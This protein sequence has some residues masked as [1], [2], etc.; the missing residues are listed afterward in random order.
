MPFLDTAFVFLLLIPVRIMGIRRQHACLK[1][2]NDCLVDQEIKPTLNFDRRNGVLQG[3][4]RCLAFNFILPLVFCT[5]LLS[6][7][8]V[9]KADGAE[10][11]DEKE[12]TIGVLAIRGKNVCRQSWQNTADYLTSRIPG[13]RFT[14]TPLDHTEINHSVADGAVDFILT[15]SSTYVELE[16]LYGINRIA[17]LKEKRHGGVYSSYGGVIFY[18]ADRQDINSLADLKGKRFAAVSENSLGG[19]Q[20]CLLEMLDSGMDPFN[21]FKTL[22]FLGTHDGVVAAVENGTADAGSVRTNILEEL[23]AEGRVQLSDF[24]VLHV[25]GR[26]YTDVPYLLT[27]REYPDWPMARVKHTAEG[28]AEKV[29][30]ALLQMENDDKA[31]LDAGCAGWTIPLNYQP[32]H[33]L[34]KKLHLGPYSDLGEITLLKVLQQYATLTFLVCLTFVILFFFTLKVMKLNRAISGSQHKLMEEIEQHK[35]LDEAL[36]EAKELAEEATRAKSQFLANM[37]HEIRTPMNGI[38]A[39]TDLALEENLSPSVDE[40]LTIVQNSSYALLGIIN[41]IL[42]FSKIEAGQMELKERVFKLD[43]MLDQVIDLFGSQASEKGIELMVD[44][45]RGMPGMLFGDALKLQQILNNLISNAIKFTLAGGTILISAG[46]GES[47][48]KKM[49]QDLVELIFSVKD[50]GIG[51]D[52]EYKERLF[53]PFSQGDSSA[54]RQHEGTGLGLSICK[55]IVAMMNGEIMVESELDKGS[56]FTFTVMLR[57]AGTMLPGAYEFPEDIKGGTALVVDDLYDSRLIIGKILASFGFNVETCSSGTEALQRLLPE[58]MVQSQ[59]DLIM[60]DWKMPDVDGITVSKRI[61]QDLQLQIPIIMMTAFGKDLQRNEAEKIGI[62]G[63]LIKPIFQSTLFDAIMDAFGKGGNLSGQ[64]QQTFTTRA[65]IYRKHLSCYKI[66]LVED[67]LTNQQVA[68]AILRKAGVTV[69]VAEN[70]R[71]AVE[72][73]QQEKF[74]AVLMDIQMPI[75]SG[76]EATKAIRDL[77]GFGNLPIIAMTAHAM[78]G[79]EEKCL[80]VGMNGYITKPINQERLFFTLRRFLHSRECLVEPV[81]SKTEAPEEHVAE[82]KIT[83][84]NASEALKL[85]SD[86]ID[87]DGILSLLGIDA[88]TM[89]KILV[90]FYRDNLDT[91]FELRTALEKGDLAQLRKMAHKLKGSGGNIGSSELADCAEKLE[92][93]CRDAEEREVDRKIVSALAEKLQRTLSE[94]LKKLELLA[95]LDRKKTVMNL[96]SPAASSLSEAVDSLLMAIEHFDPEEIEKQ[97]REVESAAQDDEVDKADIAQLGSLISGYDYASARQVARKVKDAL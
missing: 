30:V 73:V 61:R 66:L 59:V 38:I 19:W 39:A 17:T 2:M 94:V 81:Q 8:G 36:Q 74:D 56:T 72:M 85:V 68:T 42:D 48:G 20:M 32:V 35:A 91:V 47:K 55:K 88:E 14:I 21:D 70:G 53:E 49:D 69:K 46:E 10:G 64:A 96:E 83:S 6:C 54:T 75:M 92:G 51:I 13:A 24:K 31:A 82:M 45:E 29:A 77:P 40:Y 71:A 86:V 16:Y 80:E 62:N 76:Y 58:R 18:R 93:I 22:T 84:E 52:P 7:F 23:D 63:F 78:K 3:H 44:V 34:M 11:A 97:F 57:K 12:Y 5:V 33:E 79:D 15:N 60:M 9:H 26:D 95:D 67:N 41:D 50:T 90:S 87:V 89:E 65:S 43:D 27:T 28:I 37:S 4:C 25:D 1:S